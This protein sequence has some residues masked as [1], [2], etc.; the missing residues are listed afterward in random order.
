MFS[1]FLVRR[2]EQLGK[3]KKQHL[4]NKVPFSK[5]SN[6][7]S[8][9]NKNILKKKSKIKPNFSSKSQL[10]LYREVTIENKLKNPKLK[11]NFSMNSELEKNPKFSQTKV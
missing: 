6:E 4:R 11:V 5:E 8:L 10:L 9:Q 7:N 1:R 3:G 2:S